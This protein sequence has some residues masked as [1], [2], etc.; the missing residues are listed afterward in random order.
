MHIGD[1]DYDF[2]LVGAGAA[3]CTLAYRL[4]E[5]RSTTVLLVE[6]GPHDVDPLIHIPKGVAKVMA[7]PKQIWVYPSAP[8]PSNANSTE[9]WLRG[10]VLGGS[11][12][13]NGMMYVRGQPAD[14]DAIAQTTSD[15]WSWTNIAAAYKA[16]ESHELGPAETRG[17][18]GPLKLTLPNQRDS[19][20]EAMIAAGQSLG[21]VT[22]EDVNA[23][24]DIEG[25]GYAPRTIHKGRRQSAAVAFLHPIRKRPNLKILVNA[26]TDK[27]IFDDAKTAI[28]VEVL[29]D[30]RR[31]LVR[32]KEIVLCG[33]AL[34]S[35]GILERSGVGDP[36][37]LSK[38]GI[39]LIHPNPN[40]G[41][42]LIEHRCITMQW[43]LTRNISHNKKHYGLGLLFSILQYCVAR[44]GPMSAGAYEQIGWFKTKP[45][46]ARPD[47]QF[48]FAPFSLDMGKMRRDV[49]RRPGMHINGYQLRPTSRGRIHVTSP[50]PN[51][52]P[53]L[54]SNYHGT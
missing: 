53:E 3:G 44:S 42:N 18:K 27:V 12:S 39:P 52:A 40:V 13:T 29:C 45:G 17:D 35:P 24:D 20:T 15:D 7:N 46:L 31:Q 14:F 38:L 11:S 51:A 2:V 22:K 10:R 6:A 43:K 28:A 8:Q 36:E 21:W 25:L 16:L 48:L 49:E 23:P 9:Y 37:R 26:I 33:G 32:G 47:A 34:S 1:G 4:S 19:L 54:V 50:D 30:G 5:D 41:E